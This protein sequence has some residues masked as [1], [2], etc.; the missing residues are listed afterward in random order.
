MVKI[1]AECFTVLVAPH[2]ELP[3]KLADHMHNM[4]L[5]HHHALYL[6]F[7]HSLFVCALLPI[8][9]NYTKTLFQSMFHAFLALFPVVCTKINF[10]F[11]IKCNY[12]TSSIISKH[13]SICHIFYRHL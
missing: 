8:K 3:C 4:F 10:H 1:T 2:V 5:I 11:W 13:L 7:D 12:G 6:H 9:L